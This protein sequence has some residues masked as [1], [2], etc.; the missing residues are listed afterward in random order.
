[1][2]ISLATVI[3]HPDSCATG[4]SLLSWSNNNLEDNDDNEA[5]K[6]ALKPSERHKK[7]WYWQ[8]PPPFPVHL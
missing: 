8:P 6:W 3:M 5:S 4:H 1:M 2:P 7:P